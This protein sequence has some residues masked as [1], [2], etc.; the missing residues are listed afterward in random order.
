VSSSTAGT[1]NSI[2]RKRYLGDQYEP[3]TVRH[4]N[5]VL[6]SF[7]D[8]WLDVG[9]GPLIN[10]VPLRRGPGHRPHQHHN[11]LEPFRPEG[12]LRYNP[13]LPKRKPRAMPDNQ[14]NELFAGLRSNRD[15]AIVALAVSNGARAA[16]LLGVRG[17]DLRD[18]S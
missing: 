2:T 14:W 12:R 8:F 4:S 9:E 1:V 11:P 16:E 17:V 7:Y 5:A 3:T 13:R 15:R 6:R 18:V 10:P